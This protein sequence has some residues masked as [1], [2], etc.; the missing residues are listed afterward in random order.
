LDVHR[1]FCEVAIFEEGELRSAGRIK[2]SPEKLELFAGSLGPDDR[3]AL[4][5]TSGAW[6]VARI[7][8]PHV[9][10]VVV[11]SPHDTGIRQARAKTDRLDA[12]ALAKLLAS[13]ALDG[14]WVPD[15][16]TRITRRRLARRT[17][18]VRA[19]SRAKNETHACLARRLIAA[20]EVSDLF[21]LVG[22]RWLADLE[23]PREER[24][25]VGSCMRQ[26]EFLDAE[27]AEVGG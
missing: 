4:E 18:L 2:T 24:E 16:Q 19:R 23:L 8:E 25:T 9:R 17:Q 14:V 1:D 6:E 10:R 26:I 7:I 12:R 27:I 11:V 3:V 5:V 21:G 20:P 13:G 15:E 22:R